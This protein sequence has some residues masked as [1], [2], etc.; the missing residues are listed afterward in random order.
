MTTCEVRIL[1]DT[2]RETPAQTIAVG[3]ERVP[4]AGDLIACS[5]PEDWQGEA[6]PAEL[7]GAM[8][9]IEHVVWESKGP[10]VKSSPQVRAVRT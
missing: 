10:G 2:R 9:R 8:L 1:A 7:D 6:W 3:F 5:T 4:V